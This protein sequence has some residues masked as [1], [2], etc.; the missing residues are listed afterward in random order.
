[1]KKKG[2]FE[3]NKPPRRTSAEKHAAEPRGASS[4]KAA[5]L[6]AVSLACLVVI[7]LLGLCGYGMLLKNRDTIYPNVYVAGVNVGGLK[8]DAAVAAVRSAVETS[9]AANMLTVVLPDRSI[10]VE[11][12]VTKVALDPENAIETAMAYGRTGGPIKALLTYR[13]AQTEEYNVDLQSALNLDTDYIRKIIDQT[14]EDCVRTRINPRVSVNEELHT[15]AIVTGSPAYSLNADALYDAVLARFATGDY[16]D[17]HF[18]YETTPCEP[19]D[20]QSYYDKFCTEAKDAY[21]NEETHELVKEQN[22]LGFDLPYYTQQIAMAEPET[23][24]VIH[25]EEQPAEVTLEQLQKLYFADV[26][27]SYDSAHVYN[28][29]RT[30]NLELACKAIDGTIL[31]PGEEFSFNKVVGERTE[32]RGFQK[33]TV[34]TQIGSSEPETGGGVCQVAST[35]YSACLLANL[36]VT[37]R[38]PHMYLVTYVPRGMDATIYWGSQDYKFVNDTEY[39][40]RI[41]ASVSGG[42]VHIKLVGTERERDYD[43]IKLRG[44]TIAVKEWKIVMDAEKEADRKQLTIVKGGGVNEKGTPIDIAVDKDGNKYILGEEVNYP[45]T[46]YTVN[47]YRDFYDKDDNLLR[48]EF[49][50]KDVFLSRDQSF[51]VTPY[52]EPE[53]PEETS[54]DPAIDPA[55]DPLEPVDPPDPV[56]PDDPDEPVEPVDPDSDSGTGGDSG[57]WW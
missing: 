30:T 23:P 1:M 19:I 47:A 15:I 32:E 9:S 5:K 25:L 46:G 43:H 12:N 17:L 28:P 49:L 48:S 36:K 2:R 27:G 38:C 39:P 42:Y 45:Y 20:L 55:V 40:L 33:A 26:L 44:E 24:L 10:S 54:D 52:K 7:G 3:A 6:V 22:G 18:D 21:Y 13:K 56:E 16:S 11:P 14:A 57:G 51:K 35:I 53:P 41:D 31:S 4:G 50:H 29:A 37:Y 34:Y 8:S